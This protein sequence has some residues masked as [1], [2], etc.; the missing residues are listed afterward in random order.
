M[1]N[2]L[3]MI[4]IQFKK[5]TNHSKTL[6]KRAG[7]SLVVFVLSAMTLLGF[8]GL[9]IDIGMVL[10]AQQ[11]FQ[12]AVD[13]SVIVGVSNF[14][15]IKNNTNHE[16]SLATAHVTTIVN[17]ALTQALSG[18]STLSSFSITNLEIKNPSRALRIEA[19]ATTS[20]YFM[21]LL[22]IKN[23]NIVARSA[24][25]IAPMYLSAAFS[26]NPHHRKRNFRR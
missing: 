23:I 22:G 5:I 1:E 3:L 21:G 6:K 4:K 20:T 2:K 11:E 14:E 24:A 10:L 9:A 13:S 8:A 19:N 18:N 26:K 25:M 12:K 7:A 17:N 16:V 15:P